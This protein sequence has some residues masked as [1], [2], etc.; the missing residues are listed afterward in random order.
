MTGQCITILYIP[1]ARFPNRAIMKAQS[2]AEQVA[3]SPVAVV[4]SAASHRLPF[5]DHQRKSA[6][7]SGF[8]D[9]LILDPSPAPNSN[10][11]ILLF[12]S[13]LVKVS[14]P[15]NPLEKHPRIH[16]PAPPAQACSSPKSARKS[17]IVNRKCDIKAN[18]GKSRQ[19]LSGLPRR[20]QSEADAVEKI[21]TIRADPGKSALKSGKNFQEHHSWHSRALT[22]SL[23]QP[24]MKIRPH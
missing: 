10:F 12:R 11:V 4:A 7:I 19:N 23:I 16:A 5:N 24:P 14:Q 13:T 18:Q 9:P 20:S 17:Y 6:P 22:D 2:Q 1:P 15:K 8:K 21:T 3:S